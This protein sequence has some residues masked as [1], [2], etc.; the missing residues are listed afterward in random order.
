M[1]LRPSKVRIPRCFQFQV[2]GVFSIR[3]T[4]IHRN[5]LATKKRKNAA[6]NGPI[7]RATNRPAMNVPPQKIAVRNNFI[8]TIKILCSQ[9]FQFDGIK[10]S[11]IETGKFD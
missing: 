1:P 4:M 9:V 3:Q 10:L 5:M 11:E 6:L 8:R 7:S 2:T